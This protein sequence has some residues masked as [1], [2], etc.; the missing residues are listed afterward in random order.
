M[1]LPPFWCALLLIFCVALPTHTS[2]LTN[3]YEVQ[4]GDSLWEIAKRFGTSVKKIQSLNK[5]KSGRIYPGQK[6]RMGARIKEVI[7]QNGP[8]YWRGPKRSTQPSAGYSESS[9]ASASAD[10]GQGTT[11]LA[12][13]RAELSER[14]RKL[15]RRKT[16]L[17]GWR[18]VLDPGHGGRDPG[19]VVSNKD[20]RGKSVY[21]VEDEYVYDIAVRV[22]ERLMLYGAEVELTVISPNHVIRDNV[23]A[24]ATFVNEK[25]EIYNDAT[26]NRRK[27]PMVRPG[28][29]NIQR[30]VTVA[31]R[32]LKRGS[33]SKTLFLSLHADN[34]PGRP[35]GPLVIYQKK[36]GRFDKRSKQFAEVM[37]A[38]LDHPSVPSQIGSRNM[39]VLRNNS[40]RAEVLVEI[41]NVAFKGDA[42]AL[43]FHGKRQEDAERIVRGVLDYAKR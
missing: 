22:M 28:S 40:A 7:A 4:R 20:G 1:K 25:N 21:V 33:G 30:R 13:Y 18:I 27:D 32:F 38:A 35:K 17:K 8:Y 31:N 9:P 39:A 15:K 12:A 36:G 23:P 29:H 6:L 3:V 2:G 10:Y 14:Y 42:W 11:L 34:S 16:P 19:A 37:R 24:D 43:R 5:L 26:Y 41:R